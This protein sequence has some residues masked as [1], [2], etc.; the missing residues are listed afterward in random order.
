[1][2]LGAGSTNPWQMSEA[3]AVFANGGYKINSFLIHKVLDGKGQVLM[4]AKPKQA[5]EEA[6]LV[7]PARNAWVMNSMMQDVVR[8]GTA[9]KANVLKRNDLAGKTGTTN[10]SFDAWFAGYASQV[11]GITWVGF[12]TPK[13]L[14]D[15]ETG[16]GVALP[17]W[18]DY[19]A[20]VLPKLPEIPRPYPSEPSA[21]STDDAP[22][23]NPVAAAS[24]PAPA[25][26]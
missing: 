11:V 7:I 18:I 6:N 1:M 25:A 4:Q 16:G 2:A 14:G 20:K 17:I 26:Q 5:G 22:A 19:M 15:K 9:T 23:T 10:D 24:T 13:S 8:Y 3:Y 21:S 12:D